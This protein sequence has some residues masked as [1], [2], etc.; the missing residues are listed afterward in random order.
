LGKTSGKGAPQD[1]ETWLWNDEVKKKKD[2]K[3]KWDDNTARD[4]DKMA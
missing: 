3:K 2:I 4:E 1:K